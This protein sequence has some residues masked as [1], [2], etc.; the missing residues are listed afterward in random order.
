MRH[1]LHLTARGLRAF[2][3]VLC[4]LAALG[5]VTGRWAGV[6]S[7]L[8]GGGLV[9]ANHAL[10][11]LSTGWSR[12]LSPSAVAIGYAVFVVRMFA[13]FAA[14]AVL[15]QLAWVSRPL[16]A[17]SFCT[18]LVATLGAECLSYARG[19]YVPSWRTVSR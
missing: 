3:V 17:A 15:S 6:A 7:V 18:V 14:L 13:V 9:V 8:L 10:A 5:A 11:A 2:A 19:S 16:L 12:T 4:P 1:E